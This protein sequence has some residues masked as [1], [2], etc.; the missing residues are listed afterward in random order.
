MAARR[1]FQGPK[2]GR[3]FNFSAHAHKKAKGKSEKGQ[4]AVFWHFSFVTK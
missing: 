2:A 4:K 1:P 3:I